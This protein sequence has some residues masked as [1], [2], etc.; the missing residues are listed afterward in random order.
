MKTSSRF[1]AL[2]VLLPALVILSAGSSR[3]NDQRAA[4]R[5]TDDIQNAPRENPVPFESAEIR[6]LDGHFFDNSEAILYNNGPLSTGP[7]S[8][9]GVAA[10][11]GFNWSEVQNAEGDTLSSN[12]TAGFSG[13]QT[14]PTTFFRLGDNFV[15]PAGRTWTI[16]SVTFYSYQT[17]GA[18]LPFA[19]C[20]L[21]VWLGRPGDVGSIVVFGDTSTNRLSSTGSASLYRVFN[22]KYPTTVNVPGTT[23]NIQYVNV[24][25]SPALELPEGEYWLDWQTSLTTLAAHFA[26]SVTIVNR[27]G[28]PAWNARQRISTFTWQDALD[29][30]NP[31]TAP[32]SLQDFPF[33]LMGSTTGGDTLLVIYPDSATGTATNI[34]QKKADRDTTNKY[35]GLYDSSPRRTVYI[36]TT[37]ATLPNLSSYKRIVYVE[38]SFDAAVSRYMGV[39]SKT[40]LKNWLNAGTP[41]DKRRLV[42]IGADIAYNYSRANTGADTTLS[43]Q[44]LK[45]VYVVDNGNTAGSV[46]GIAVNT[47]QTFAYST[48]VGGFWPDGCNYRAGGVTLYKYTG[49]ATADSNA[50]IGYVGTGYTSACVFQDPRYYTGT[51]GPVLRSALNYSG[52]VTDVRPYSSELPEDFTLSQNYPNPFNPS[53]TIQY[54]LVNSTT[55]SLR[56]YDILGREVVTL[57]NGPQAAGTYQVIWDGRNSAGSQVSSGVYFYRLEAKTGSDASKFTSL[58]K[59]MLLLK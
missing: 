44:M 28:Q 22:S 27:R 15:V 4:T 26:P 46:T 53:T 10:P 57:A 11:A 43:H 20:N 34:A 21:Q 7:T 6:T 42:M 50:A 59:K 5:T 47:G 25:V 56:V 14:S 29:A 12:G 17:G 54:G 39:S 19:G 1:F 40:A 33:I 16:D 31:A 8:K 58:K 23:R 51:F 48:T 36:D 38:S 55:V 32:D 35:L 30:G 9:S 45:F 13:G 49:R 3:A 52:I 37:G 2:L 24:R 18:G 41:S